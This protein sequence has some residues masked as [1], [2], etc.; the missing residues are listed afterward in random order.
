MEPGV[1][2]G[3]AVLVRSWLLTR[4]ALGVRRMGVGMPRAGV[5]NVCPAPRSGFPIGLTGQV[6]CW[7]DRQ[8]RVLWVMEHG[9]TGGEGW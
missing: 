8:T 2:P 7:P 5:P 1:E 6:S 3:T 4:F 9:L